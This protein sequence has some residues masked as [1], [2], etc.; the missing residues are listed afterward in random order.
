MKLFNLSRKNST[1]ERLSA[2]IVV[3]TPGFLTMFLAQSSRMFFLMNLWE[4][5]IKG[6]K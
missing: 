1:I 2:I 6:G 3:P 4:Q 5:N